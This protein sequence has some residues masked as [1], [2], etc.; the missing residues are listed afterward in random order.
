MNAFH[1]EQI[2]SYTNFLNKK[3]RVM[4]GVLNNEHASWQQAGSIAA[5]AS[6]AM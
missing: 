2:G 6:V 4:N 5:R 1:H 3:S